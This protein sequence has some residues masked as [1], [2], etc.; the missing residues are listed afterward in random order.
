[1]SM[2]TSHSPAETVVEI[3]KGTEWDTGLDLDLLLEIAAHFKDVRRKY[4]AFESAFVGA[5]TRILA[6]QVPGG[7]L[8]NLES[9]LK[10]QEAAHRIDEVLREI[11]VVQK[12]FGYPPLVTP[13]I[14]RASCRERV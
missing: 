9:Q 12:D 7:M 5:D 4:R 2:G 10:E 3:L 11:A 6:S 13:K 8:S 1:M 14:G